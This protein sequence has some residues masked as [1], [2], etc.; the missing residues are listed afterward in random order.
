MSAEA[1]LYRAYLAVMHESVLPKLS[2]TERQ[3]VA[4]E[5][6]QRSRATTP[7]P[8]RQAG[9]PGNRRPESFREAAERMLHK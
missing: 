1:A 8:T 4:S 6:Q 7:N 3:A 9:Q 5:L 2:S